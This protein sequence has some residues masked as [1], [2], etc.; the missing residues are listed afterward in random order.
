MK[1]NT[2]KNLKNNISN[3]KI[4]NEKV[5]ENK[6]KKERKKVKKS[7]KVGEKRQYNDKFHSIIWYVFIFTIVGLLLE[8]AYAFIYTNVFKT[9]KGL[10]LGPFCIIYGI[11]AAI[12]ITI[13]DKF[14][15]HK[16]K[17]FICGSV[18]GLLS[19]YIISFIIDALNGG[20]IWNLIYQFNL[21]GRTCLIH[22][23]IMGILAILLI[24]IAKN[25]VDCISKKIKGIAR[26]IID[27]IIIILIVINIL[28]AI[29][30]LSAYK[31]RASDI[32]YEVKIF[33]EK[34]FIDK[35]ADKIFSD[36]LLINLYPNARFI[37]DNGNIV[38]LKDQFKN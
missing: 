33:E 6:L 20:R 32:Y 24:N 8:F 21:N 7:T 10:I 13:L 23:I 27:T 2:G 5:E 31:Q 17:L 9:P 34:N 16:L 3:K 1:N 28:L 15:G 18:L 12:F 14:K 35:A 37:D 19:E 25:I 29:W 11:E 38:W 36:E 22:A 26:N 30:G 4:N